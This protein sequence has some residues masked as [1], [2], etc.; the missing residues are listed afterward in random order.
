ML[1]IDSHLDI[2]Y[3]ALSWDRD[4]TQSI[5]RMRESE[6]GM[7]EKGRGLN[8]VS[9]EELR[10]GEIGL[11]FVTLCCRVGSQGKRF[12]GV[13]TQD[14]AYASDRG[15][16][17]YY[18]LLAQKGV[19]RQIRN[20][21]DLESHLQAWDADPEHCPLGFVLTMEGCDGI[22]DDAQVP[23]WWNEGLRVVSLCHYGISSY[24]HGTE[25][26]GGLTPR[27]APM[28]QALEQAGIM[29]DLSHLAESAFWEALDAFGGHVL[30]THNCVRALCD[31]DR[32]FDD[33]QLRA[34][35]QRQGVIGVAFDDWMLSHLWDK[36]AQDN[37]GITLATV[38]D[39][40]DHINQLA[41]NARH[42]AIGT[43]LDGGYGKEQSPE[44]LDTIAD[45]QKI[46]EILSRRGY[47]DDDIGAM[48]HGNWLRILRQGLP[49]E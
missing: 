5:Q 9:F 7:P 18:Q 16:L 19:L 21:A 24:S 35:I 14:I 22:V 25:A 30:A 4:P 27:G 37:T 31:H 36:Q 40:M 23:Q 15:Q 46:P 8:V 13:R 38:A 47:S 41:G 44:D 12:P 33:D 42:A 17:A 49:G 34:I 29:L 11:F 26:P 10:R 45:L 6:A 1:I 28:L 48:M 3:N 39:H 43:D 2:A 32:Q 20:T